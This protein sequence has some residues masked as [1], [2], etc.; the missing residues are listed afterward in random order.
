VTARSRLTSLQR[1]VSQARLAPLDAAQQPS[2]ALGLQYAS[3]EKR[4]LGDASL[5]QAPVISATA[6]DDNERYKGA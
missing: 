2:V 4:P 6:M 5:S 3:Q 1:R